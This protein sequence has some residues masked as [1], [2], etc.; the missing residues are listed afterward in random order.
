MRPGSCWGLHIYHYPNQPFCKATMCTYDTSGIW[1]RLFVNGVLE[2]LTSGQT[3][4]ASGSRLAKQ[5]QAAWWKIQGEIRNTVGGGGGRAGG[6]ANPPCF[7]T[8]PTRG[9]TEPAL[10]KEA[11]A[12]RAQPSQPCPLTASVMRCHIASAPEGE[13]T[14]FCGQRAL[15]WLQV[16]WNLAEVGF[17]C[18]ETLALL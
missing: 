12:L 10:L 11:A 8:L 14:T 18:E 2:S 3:P 6:M 16:G 15:R 13:R 9:Q 7:A 1:T 4:K 5:E 17:E